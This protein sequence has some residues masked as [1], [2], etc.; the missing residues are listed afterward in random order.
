MRTRRPRS[1]E[2]MNHQILGI[3]NITEDS[4]SDGGQYLE[5]EAAIAH[6]LRARG[7]RRRHARLGAASSNPD[8]KA[9]SRR[10]RDRAARAPV[11]RESSGR[12][13]SPS[14]STRF[15]PRGPALGAEQGVAYLNDIQGFPDPALY[16]RWPS[17][18]AKL[19]VMHSVQDAPRAARIDVAA[20]RDHGSD[21]DLL[22]GAGCRS[23]AR[24][25]SRRERLILDPGMGFFL[26]TRRRKPR[27]Q[28]LRGLR[29]PSRRLRPAGLWSR[30]RANLPA[31]A[32][33]PAARRGRSGHPG[34]GTVCGS[35][36]GGLYPHPRA[37]GAR[38]GAAVQQALEG[39]GQV[40]DLWAKACPGTKSARIRSH[41]KPEGTCAGDDFRLS[42]NCFGTDG[43]RGPRQQRPDDARA[44]P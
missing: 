38:D 44:S 40:I 6:A 10:C 26:G 4:F 2:V 31:E 28:V 13:A 14:R 1:S 42:R 27:S 43:I 9:V 32:H 24:P 30:C 35:P 37:G 41:Q 23:R 20:G 11:V 36:G 3:L 18:N 33:R 19:I 21:P 34:G 39:D 5:P 7:R 29:T 12:G 15:S 17:A 8:S 16:R 22:R 25:A